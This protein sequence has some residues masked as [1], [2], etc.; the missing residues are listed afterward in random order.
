[1]IDKSRS[2]RVLFRPAPT[3]AIRPA[4]RTVP[5]ATSSAQNVLAYAL[6]RLAEGASLSAAEAAEAFGVVMRGEATALQIAA[7]LMGLRAKGES[8][9]EI[10]GAARALREAMVPLAVEDA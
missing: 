3:T 10:A 9:E 7:L 5:L 8:A 4:A 6:R 2:R 1:M